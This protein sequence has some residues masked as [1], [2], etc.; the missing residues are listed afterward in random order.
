[1]EGCTQ[2]EDEDREEVVER[3]D[4]GLDDAV[5]DVKHDRTLEGDEGTDA[6]EEIT[7]VDVGVVVGLVDLVA[8]EVT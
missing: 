8:V 6:D 7:R 1:M 5:S 4:D 2:D 3:G